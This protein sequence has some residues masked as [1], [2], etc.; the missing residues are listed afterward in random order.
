MRLPICILV[1]TL[2][3]H[4]CGG[5]SGD[6]PAPTWVGAWSTAPMCF[7]AATIL[8]L[9]RTLQFADQS[10][11]MVVRT[12]IGGSSIRV[13]L[14]NQ[15]GDAPLEIGAATV[16]IRDEG[17]SIR[18]GTIRALRFDDRPSVTVPAGAVVTSDP[19]ELDVP[20]LGDLAISLYFP[21]ATVPTTSHPLGA[22]GYSSGGGD[23]TSA[24]DGAPFKA[25]MNHWVFLDAV[26]VRADDGAVAIV[27]FGDSVTEG[28]G[29][30][31][32]A[33]RRWPDFLARRLV[34]AGKRFGVLN[35]GINGNKVLNSL[36]GESA[37]RRFDKDV[38]GQAG[39][40]YV[41][42]LEGINDIG[43]GNPDVTADEIIAGYRE[44]IERAHAN[45]LLI[46][47]GTLTP[48]E[49]TPYAFYEPYEE[50]KRVAVNRFIRESGAFDAVIDFAAAVSDPADPAH[51]REGFSGDA[52][53]P[54]D[55]GAEA[56]AGAVDLSLFR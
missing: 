26:E 39:V 17:A 49:G 3:L 13:K 20:A 25:A 43:L 23:F 56:L 8:G 5:G 16:G 19:V 2:A 44:L 14:T 42:L 53:H 33:N 21:Q 46:F 52:L 40:K 1:A 41:I 50:E 48:A 6:G 10:V 18:P 32:D 34:A 27:A 47:G 51:W 9:S 11:R 45:G 22:R 24:V 30:T 36:L 37:L 35:Q 38:L 29:T 31:F 4:A 15:C 55:A 7:Q 12:S 28:T 54:S